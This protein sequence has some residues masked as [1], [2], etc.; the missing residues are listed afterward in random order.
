MIKIV[1]VVL[2][3]LLATIGFLHLQT[4]RPCQV[5]QSEIWDETLSE[6][7]QRGFD[8]CGTFHSAMSGDDDAIAR[9]LEFS[10]CT[11]AASALGHGCA[12]VGVL[13]TLGDDR[14]AAC[15]RRQSAK[16]RERLG[17]IIECGIEYGMGEKPVD[18]AKLFPSSYN[19]VM[20][21]SP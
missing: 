16:L 19:A 10:N 5:C 1:A 2:L 3:I 8:Y 9:L 14:L 20:Q 11:D 17:R 15:I 7:A 18:M 12:I 13:Q 4:Q 6:A 21:G